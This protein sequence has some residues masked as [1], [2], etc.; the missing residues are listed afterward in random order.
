MSDDIQ[1]QFRDGAEAYA[2]RLR[3]AKAAKQNPKVNTAANGAAFAALMQARL[4]Q[5]DADSGIGDI[6]IPRNN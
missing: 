2:Q 4:D 3:D 5:L 6:A 1:Q